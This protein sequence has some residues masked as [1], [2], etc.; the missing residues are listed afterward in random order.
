MTTTEQAV[1]GPD[2]LIITDPGRIIDPAY[3]AAYL[4]QLAGRAL[5]GADRD[6]PFTD[7]DSRGRHAAF[8]V[9]YLDQGVRNLAE[10]IREVSGRHA[11]Q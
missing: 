1:P 11:E 2:Q 7:A 6:Y 4:E 8:R 10:R 3:I 5:T 9:G